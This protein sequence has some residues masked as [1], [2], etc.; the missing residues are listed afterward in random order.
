VL[1]DNDHLL[2][3][4][5]GTC[6][7]Q[8]LLGQGGMGAVYLAQQSR[9][10]R[11]VA[12]KVLIHS[13]IVNTVSHRD[14]L[15]RFRREADAIAALDH[16]NIMP[17]YEYGEQEQLA[18]LVMP[19]ITGGSLREVLV[20][21]HILPLHETL[22]II[23]QAAAALDYAHSRGIVHRDIKP[24]NMLFHS[25]GRLL[26]ADF[27][28]AKVLH[29]TPSANQETSGLVTNTGMIIGTPQ[30][31]SP[32][33]AAGIPVDRFSDIYS[34][35]IVLFQMLGGCVPFTGGTVV[36]IAMKHLQM[37]P[38][39]LIQLNPTLPYAVEA[40]V[41][42]A[43][44]KK[45]H[46]RYA[47]AGQLAQALRAAIPGSYL[48]QTP[49]KV[50]ERTTPM[51]PM[52]K[53]T[54]AIPDLPLPSAFAPSTPG[55]TTVKTANSPT[56]NTPWQQQLE[57]NSNRSSGA[58][59]RP[60]TGCQSSWMLL[61]SGLLVLTLL[62]GGTLAYV[63]LALHGQFAFNGSAA[64]HTST[65]NSPPSM[66][67]TAVI[68][69]G[70]QLYGTS[71]PGLSCDKHGGQWTQA[72]NAQLICGPSA[73]E[74]RNTGTHF[75]AGAF[76]DGLPGGFG[77]P[78]D[79]IL[80]VQVSQNPASHGPFGV[81]FRNQPGANHQGT[82]SFLLS[83]PG[84]WQ[85]YSYDDVS[86]HATLLSTGQTTISPGTPIIIDI[87]VHANTFTF[88]LNGVKQGMVTSQSYPSGTLGL[89]VDVGADALFSN[90]AL[91]RLP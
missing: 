4:T 43:L 57:V 85:A 63:R 16:I 65:H 90:L 58:R 73:T 88:Y 38:P 9:P 32:E 86:G 59:K 46:L 84:T 23:E 33:Q 17:I 31:F 76:L 40:V 55:A 45:P 25:D 60:R 69:V 70:K 68:P 6:T 8:S 42:R 71:L 2:G 7:L 13:S 36:A 48:S 12:V 27:G 29:E 21:R 51:V 66:L 81:F 54:L 75:L 18:F 20:R 3:K 62:V 19:H 52:S 53:N 39:S 50:A 67:I 64:Q 28:L 49:Y 61:L 82:F 47:S 41:T 34:L 72:P 78:D 14:F 10:R 89:A 24:G 77:I 80:Q 79:Y 56:H 5:L 83:P 15:A 91:Y 1:T 22:S 37:E 74:L 30:Y 26:L 44:A 35:G 87:V 11:T